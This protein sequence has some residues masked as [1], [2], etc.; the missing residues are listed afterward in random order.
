MCDCVYTVQCTSIEYWTL[1]SISIIQNDYVYCSLSCSRCLLLLSP[2]YDLLQ[3]STRFLSSFYTISVALLAHSLTIY[4]RLCAIALCD[5]SHSGDFT[6][7]KGRHHLNHIEGIDL[8]LLK[9]CT[10]AEVSKIR[11]AMLLHGTYKY[12]HDICTICV[13]NSIMHACNI[14]IIAL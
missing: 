5:I 9:V 6:W 10:R 13:Y 1:V 2:S 4:F 14:I 12:M 8:N 3:Q 7:K 11:N